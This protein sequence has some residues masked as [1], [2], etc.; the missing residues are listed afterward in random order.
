MYAVSAM[1]ATCTSRVSSSLL[2]SRSLYKVV[3]IWPGQTVTCLHTN[4]PVIFEPPCTWSVQMTKVVVKHFCPFLCRGVKT[5]STNT[6]PSNTVHAMEHWAVL[7]E[8][9]HA[10][11]SDT[12]CQTVRRHEPEYCTAQRCASHPLTLSLCLSVS[13]SL[14]ARDS[15]SHS[16]KT[17]YKT[18]LCLIQLQVYRRFRK[19]SKI[20]C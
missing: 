15:A 12:T 5:T 7:C 13:L 11:D 8:Y 9:C 19:I 20:D 6:P 17:T 2:S 16:C 14:W 18:N 1:R 10:D 3:Q 4:R